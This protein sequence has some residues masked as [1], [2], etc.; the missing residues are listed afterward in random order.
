MPGRKSLFSTLLVAVVFLAACNLP[1]AQQKAPNAV[2]TEAAQTIEAKFTQSFLLTPSATFTPL[3]TQT[4][5]PPAATLTPVT[6]LTPTPT[7][8]LAGYVT[9]VSVPDG[10]QFQPGQSFTKTWRLKN[11]GVCTWTSG[12]QVIFDNGDSMSGPATQAL[13]GA[14]SPSQSVDIS[15][16]LKAPSAAG[17]FRGYWKLRNATGVLLPV[18]A[19]Y[20]GNSFFVDIRVALPEPTQTVTVTPTPNPTANP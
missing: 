14:V 8:D 16:N 4:P 9:D 7:C 18:V 5:L 1:S 10:T 20:Q 13:A 15:V 12:Y 11:I 2:Y 17:S 19:G 3:L 6:S